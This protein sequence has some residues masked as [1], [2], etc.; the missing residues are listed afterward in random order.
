MTIADATDAVCHLLVLL[1]WIYMG[2]DF[3]G[4]LLYS[5]LNSI[6][7]IKHFQHKDEF[8]CVPFL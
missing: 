1:G 4:K 5:L 7:F 2:T 3:P 8:Y 6:L